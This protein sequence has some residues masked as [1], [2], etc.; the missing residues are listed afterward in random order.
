MYSIVILRYLFW[1]LITIVKQIIWVSSGS[2]K[3]YTLKKFLIPVLI[4]LKNHSLIAASQLIDISC[5]DYLNSTYRFHLHYFLL[6]L[7]SNIRFQL[8][9][10]ICS[11]T[12]VTS[13][14]KLFTSAYWLERETWD[15]F[16]ILFVNHY[17]LRRLLTDYGFNG[18]PLIK[19]FPLTGYTEIFYDDGQKTILKEQVELAQEYRVFSLF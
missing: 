19:N 10:P 11:F 9:I 6:S 17:N 16:G 7:L 5:V 1:I 15:M 12:S 4:I 18:Y 13:I 3:L 2:I 14:T 8:I